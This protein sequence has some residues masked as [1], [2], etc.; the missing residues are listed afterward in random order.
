MYDDEAEIK[1]K[2]QKLIIAIDAIR[3]II[4]NTI[5]PTIAA[6]AIIA[7]KYNFISCSNNSSSNIKRIVKKKLRF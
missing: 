2:R 6:I 4:S 3:I 1:K 5:N 7:V